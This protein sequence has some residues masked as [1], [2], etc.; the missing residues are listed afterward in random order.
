MRIIPFTITTIITIVLIWA[1]SRPW[2]RVPAIGSFLSPQHGFWQNAEPSDGSFALDLDFPQLKNKVEVY[3]D[4]RMVPHVFAQN[5]EDLFFV[6]GYIHAKYRLW[7]MEF[8]THAAAGRLSEILGSGENDLIVKFDRQ[9]RRLGMVYGAKNSEK[10]VEE[11]KETKRACDS[12]TAGVNAYINELT[13]ASLPLEYKLLNYHPEKWTNLKTALFLKYMSYDLAAPENDFEYTNAKSAL[14]AVDFEK[15]FPITQD[16]LVPIVPKGTVFDP[17]AVH[18]Q[19]PAS[20][21]SLYFASKTIASIVRSRPDPDNG[22]NNWAVDG[23]KTQS[24]RPILCNDPHL[25]LNLPSLWFEM[26]L[27][28]PEFNAYGASFPGAPCVIIGFND[29]CAFGFTNAMR[30]VRDY[31]SID[32][33][34]NSKQ[35]YY[36]NGEWKKSELKIDTLKIKGREPFYDTVAYTVF[37]PVMYDNSFRGLENTRSDGK[38]YAVKWKAHDPSDELMLFYKLNH[39]KNYKDYQ[40][41]L[42]YLTC[43]GQNCLF[44]CKDGDIAVWQQAVFPAKWRRQGDFIMPGR[45]SSYDWQGYIPQRENPHLV[46]PTNGIISTANQ[47]PVDTTYPYY[48]G[49]H[50]DLYRGIEINRFLSQMTGI[51]PDAMK[52]LQTNNYNGLAEAAVPILLKNLDQSNLND[53]EKKY[54]EMLQNWNYRNDPEENGATVFLNWF[55]SLQL[56]IWNDE[57]S[58]MPQPVDLPEDYT[59]I[60]LLKKDSALKFVDN[61]NT[62]EVET[63]RNVVTNAFRKAVPGLANLEAEGM[64]GWSKYKDSGIQHLLRLGALS[65]FHLTTGGGKHVINATKKYHGPSWRMI[66]HLTDQTEA[67]GV[68][69]GGQS[70]NPGSKYYDGFVDDW[71]AGKYY[72]LWMMKATEKNDKRIIG[73]MNFTKFGNN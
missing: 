63:L 57:F 28:T 33:R 18:P 34:D 19:K 72:S 15:L 20:A 31:F 51:T 38:N 70:G 43:P 61:I 14:S 45:D 54:L 13:A 10:K 5:E 73:K 67:Y 41:A 7:Q 2:G 58:K 9:M 23:T 25:G 52:Q 50:H 59:L 1:L 8:Q 16:S 36:Y 12:Y 66:V 69:P 21:D 35:E 64:L 42:Q 47:L 39:A 60:E 17:P 65:R 49:G 68:Y 30:D 32:F 71:A 27:S 24:G 4:E 46:K 3:F 29:N 55:D 53:Q 6:Q 44:A 26:Q 22:S 62:P 48:V 37:G 56:E 11:D 40:D